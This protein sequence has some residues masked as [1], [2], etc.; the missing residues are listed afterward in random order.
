LVVS[1][2]GTEELGAVLPVGVVVTAITRPF[3]NAMGGRKGPSV[4]PLPEG[5]AIHPF[6]AVV[7]K[8]MPPVVAASKYWTYTVP[9]FVFD[10]L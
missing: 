1:T 9:A 4:T 7:P 8:V 3:W 5:T 10:T 6:G 2:I